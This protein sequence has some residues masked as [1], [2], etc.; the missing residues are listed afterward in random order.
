M[1]Y[2]Q[3]LELIPVSKTLEGS[4]LIILMHLRNHSILCYLLA[5]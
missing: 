1:V 5:L 4:Y 3:S 2:L